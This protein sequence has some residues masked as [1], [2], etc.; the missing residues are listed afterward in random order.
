MNKVLVINY[1]NTMY[2]H[3]LKEYESV[4]VKSALIHT[5]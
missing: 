2:T 4:P 1:V 5:F 3:P